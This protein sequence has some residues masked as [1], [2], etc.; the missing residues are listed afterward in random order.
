MQR[1]RV[2]GFTL[3]E[4][5]LVVLL[6]GLMAA[7]VTLSIGG[8]NQQQQLA[9]E[10]QRFITVTEAVTNEAV[11]SGQFVGIVVDKDAYHYVVY[12]DDKW[13]PLQRDNLLA[14]HKL[15]QGITTDLQVEGLPLDQEEQKDSLFDDDKPFNDDK[16]DDKNP[17]PQIMLLPSGEMTGFELT[18]IANGGEQQYEQLVS[19]DNLG[20]LVMGRFDDATQ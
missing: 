9:R 10:A 2:Q 8:G 1:L 18:F 11:L 13:Q 3:L 19:G 16:K 12:V 4:V 20:R 6:M 5:M 14:E 17:E 7:A 15:P